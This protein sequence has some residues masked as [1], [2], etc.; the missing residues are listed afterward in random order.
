MAFE[1]TDSPADHLCVIGV[2]VGRWYWSRDTS[3]PAG[4]DFMLPELCCTAGA[5]GGIGRCWLILVIR[6]LSFFLILRGLM[7]QRS[8]S[9]SY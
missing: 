1:M 5:M 7:T 6:R 3:P 2:G 4:V 9:A 8:R